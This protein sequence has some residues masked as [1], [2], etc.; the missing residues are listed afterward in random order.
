MHVIEYV[1]MYLIKQPKER[2]SKVGQNNV[3]SYGM[4]VWTELT[5]T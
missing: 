5:V 2:G 4:C 3:F 1:N